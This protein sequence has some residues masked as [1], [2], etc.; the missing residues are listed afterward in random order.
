M[1]Q[2]LITGSN[3]YIGIN[4]KKWLMKSP[5]QYCVDTIDIKGK[6][7]KEKYFSKYDVI[8]HVAGIVHKKETKKNQSLYY[9][10]NRDLTYEIAKKAKI[11]GVRQF[12]FLSSMSVY[13]VEK[14]VIDENTPIKPISNY[15]KSKYQA[16]CLLKQLE[17]KDFKIAIL[18]PPMV[19]GRGCKGN[20]SK[21]AKLVLKSPMFPEINSKHSMIYIGNLCEFIKILIDDCTSGLFFPQNEEYVCISEMVKEIAKTHNKTIFLIRAFNPILKLVKSGI[22]KKIFADLVYEKRISKYSKNYSIFD[23]ESSIFLTE[24]DKNDE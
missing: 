22:V 12:I 23:F 14:G 8:F 3:S 4:L 5:E 2:I 1:L 20:Y 13:G 10:V 6:A 9:K 19:Y 7:W 15:G 16:E 18:R 17:N 24:K 11:D 21:L